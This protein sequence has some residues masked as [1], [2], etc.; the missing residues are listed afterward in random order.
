MAA[1]CRPPSP[2]RPGTGPSCTQGRSRERDVDAAR[3]AAA[4]RGGPAAHAAPSRRRR[5]HRRGG[6][7]SE[8]IGLPAG[9]APD[10]RGGAAVV[11]VVPPVPAGGELHQEPRMLVGAGPGP[12]WDEVP[13]APGT[14]ARLPARRVPEA[15]VAGGVDHLRPAGGRQGGEGRGGREDLVRAA[16]HGHAGHGGQDQHDGNG[17]GQHGPAATA[18]EGGLEGGAAEGGLVGHGVG[19]TRRTG[20][21]WSWAGLRGGFPARRSSA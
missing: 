17:A 20:P 19:Q 18:A 11:A 6:S 16:E 9:E 8:L 2:A 7:E 14:L 4:G 15:E 1:G 21:R 12:G 3:P 5:S 13:P 10:P